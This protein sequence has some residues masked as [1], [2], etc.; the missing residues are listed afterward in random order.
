MDKLHKSL[1]KGKSL[2]KALREKDSELREILRNMNSWKQ[3]T[4]EK[5]AKKFQEEMNR[6]L[7]K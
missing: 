1:G 3:Q 5:L 4:T 2:S 7:E 6:E